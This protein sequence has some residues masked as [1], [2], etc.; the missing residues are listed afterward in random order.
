MRRKRGLE[1]EGRVNRISL[2]EFFIV[3]DM[4]LDIPAFR[5]G[6]H[7]YRGDRDGL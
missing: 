2:S 6:F 7:G 3:P 4:A 5:V 1:E